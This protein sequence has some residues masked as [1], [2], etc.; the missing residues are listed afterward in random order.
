MRGSS[1]ADDI[2][3]MQPAFLLRGFF[4][5][6]AAFALMLAGQY[7][8]GAGLAADADEAALMQAVV[9]Q[10]QHADVAPHLFA[11]HLRQRV[12]LVQGAFRR[13]ERRVDFQRRHLAASAGALVAALAGG[14]GA[15]TCEFAAQ[16]FDLADAAAFAMAVL[17]EAEQAFLF[18][19][20]LQ[21]A[22]VRRDQFY[23]DL[24]ELTCSINR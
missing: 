21:L 1:L 11:G 24:V 5:P 13:G 2:P 10:L 9:R 20:G 16:R 18:D 4:P 14:P 3:R 12:E 6:P 7:R 17:I 23:V 19:E 8:P 15:D 22:R